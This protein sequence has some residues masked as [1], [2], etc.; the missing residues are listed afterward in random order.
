MPLPAANA[1]RESG[2]VTSGVTPGPLRVPFAARSATLRENV[3]LLSSGGSHHPPGREIGEPRWTATANL[4]QTNAAP[5]TAACCHSIALRPGISRSRTL[6]VTHADTYWQNGRRLCTAE[7]SGSNPLR[8]TSS[9]G[10]FAGV[11]RFHEALASA[12]KCP[13]ANILQTNGLAEGGSRWLSAALEGNRER[14]A[15]AAGK[16]LGREKHEA[17]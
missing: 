17:Y 1:S 3:H 11:L 14:R 4:R 10:L 2:A 8:S 15:A 13:S 9:L 7:V 5:R 16:G 6:S 12:S